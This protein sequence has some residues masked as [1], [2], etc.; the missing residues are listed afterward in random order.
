MGVVTLIFTVSKV[1]LNIPIF[2]SGNFNRKQSSMCSQTNRED[3][4]SRRSGRWRR[5][6]RSGDAFVGPP[7]PPPTSAICHLPDLRESESRS[8]KR[9]SGDNEECCVSRTQLHKLDDSALVACGVDVRLARTARTGERIGALV[10]RVH[11]VFNHDDPARILGCTDY[12]EIKN[13]YIR[14]SHLL[15]SDGRER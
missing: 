6:S 4:L 14:L 7:G 1:F 3:G 12:A 9:P 15:D 11:S 13:C 10:Q 5:T 2:F 8:N